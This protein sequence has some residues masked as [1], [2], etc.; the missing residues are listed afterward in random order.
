L[1]E[2]IGTQFGNYKILNKLG[3]GGMA[4]VYRAQQTNL[5]REVAIK[6][7]S[8]NIAAMPDFVR[9]FEQEAKLVA[10]LDHPHILK[11]FDYG[12][13]DNLIYLVMEI[14]KG[15]AL[16][17]LMRQSRLTLEQIADLL[18]QLAP[19]LDYA[20]QKGIIHRDLK[21]QN[22]LLSED[23]KNAFLTD[24]GIAKLLGQPT[25]Y[26]QTG[27]A[28]GTPAYMAPEQWA[29]R[30]VDARTDIYALGIMVY[31][32]LVGRVPFT[33]ETPLAVM[34]GHVQEPLPSL[35]TARADIPP[36]V[37]HVIAKAAAKEPDQRFQSVGEFTA[38]FR[39]ALTG[40]APSLPDGPRTAPNLTAPSKQGRNWILFIVAGVIALLIIGGGL[41]LLLPLFSK[42]DATPTAVVVV[43]TSLDP[44]RTSTATNTVTASATNTA[45]PSSTP[46]VTPSFTVLPTHI[47]LPTATNSPTA[48]LSPTPNLSVVGG[49]IPYDDFQNSQ[50]NGV[51]NPNLWSPDGASFS[52]AQ[53]TGTLVISN[54]IAQTNQKLNLDL[55]VP[56]RRSATQM[57]YF[58][59]KIKAGDDHNGG[60]TATGLTIISDSLNGHTWWT[61]CV[62]EDWGTSKPVDLAC[63]VNN[64]AT[65]NNAP[66]TECL[67]V[68]SS[69]IP[70]NTW[71]TAQIEL[72]PA[73]IAVTFT[74][75]GRKLLTC[76]T[77]FATYLTQ[78]DF[79]PSL[80]S[81][82]A[83][84]SSQT[85]YFSDVQ[86]TAIP[87]LPYGVVS[88][89]T[90]SL[91]GATAT[92]TLSGKMLVLGYTPDSQ[93]YQE[94]AQACRQPCSV[95]VLKSL[96]DLPD[97]WLIYTYHVAS[98]TMNL[99]TVCRTKAQ[100]KALKVIKMI[101]NDWTNCPT[102]TPTV[103]AATGP[104]LV[105]D[106]GF[107]AQMNGSGWIWDGHSPIQM[108]PGHSGKQAVCSIAN[109]AKGLLFIG[110]AQEIDVSKI[111]PGKTYVFSSF[112]KWENA[113]QVHLAVRYKV[114]G[115][116]DYTYRQ[117]TTPTNDPSNGWYLMGGTFT[118]PDGITDLQIVI[119]HGTFD[120]QTP[121][122]GTKL[123]IDDV[124]FAMQ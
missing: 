81:F 78:L 9:R 96:D 75:D 3:E 97:E 88:A 8:L 109:G 86:I 31:E 47:P 94:S 22:I 6:V 37:E 4:T 122:V 18:D 100:L 38:A 35:R 68:A 99:G 14:K 103:P 113:G 80:E 21:P 19:A 90:G 89:P 104:N 40:H 33:G 65:P 54:A 53:Q 50:Y 58:S 23:H 12:H 29:G 91:A 123:C 98:S 101:A 70:R 84:S 77:Q 13:H 59:A 85:S 46:T 111:I 20:H 114:P 72:D 64:N 30:T 79:Q 10:G 28:M 49:P 57:R 41:W 32:M 107:E 27:V 34:Y 87:A 71:H 39:A 5:G 55:S 17:R 106:P 61:L 82:R 69:N 73:T 116:T 56:G 76:P 36:A 121:A 115:S 74:V 42:T 102:F 63:S 93:T 44:T 66:T 1:A 119:W 83:A 25:S 52:I 108:E 48:T 16:D 112:L 62:I 24:F 105:Q 95:V 15:G 110:M 118:I 67:R 60:Y 2:L 43:A 45:L 51:Y 92:Y 124:V 26:T 11:V 7:M 120:G 117:V